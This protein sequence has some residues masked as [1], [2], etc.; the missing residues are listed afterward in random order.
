MQ[1][2]DMM[3]RVDPRGC[4]GTRRNAARKLYRSER[5]RVSFF[6]VEHALRRLG[7]TRTDTPAPVKVPAAPV[8]EV[9]DAAAVKA[10]KERAAKD[11]KNA[12]ARAKRA[13]AKLAEAA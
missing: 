5:T 2:R 7:V 11:R 13:A 1:L 9:I 8:A 3:T 6:A 10:A 12:A 4:R